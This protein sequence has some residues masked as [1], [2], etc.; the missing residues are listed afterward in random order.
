MADAA[1]PGGLRSFQTLLGLLERSFPV[2]HAYNLLGQDFTY[3]PSSLADADL[4]VEATKIWNCVSLLGS[5][6]DEFVASF[7]VSDL[8]SSVA[9][10]ESLLRKVAR[11]EH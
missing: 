11:N 7:A 1:G 3:A 10:P 6:Q 4:V 5:T 8:F 2:D 9:D